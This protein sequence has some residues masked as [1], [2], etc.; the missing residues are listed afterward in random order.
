MPIKHEAKLSGL[1][2]SSGMR[3]HAECF[4]LHIARAASKTYAA[5]RA[6]KIESSFGGHG[7]F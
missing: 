3:Q 2:G 7:D 6:N 1:L 4:I 5:D